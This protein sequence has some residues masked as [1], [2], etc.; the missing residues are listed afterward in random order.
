MH[1]A[2]STAMGFDFIL[3]CV[4]GFKMFWDSNDRGLNTWNLLFKDGL[5]FFVVAFAANILPAVG[6]ANSK[7]RDRS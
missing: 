4:G 1:L 6:V 3:L 2:L 7:C 5:V